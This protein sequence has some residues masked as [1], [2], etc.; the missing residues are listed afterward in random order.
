MK[1]GNVTLDNNIVLAPMAGITDKTYRSLAKKM[2]AGLVVT[3]MVSAKGLYYNDK[4]TDTL[5][6]ISDIE[7][8]VALQIFGSD[9]DI[10]ASVVKNNINNRLDID[11]ID[12]N[13]GCPAPKIVKNNDGSA[14]MKNPDLVKEIIYKVVNASKKPVTIKTRMGWDHKNLN[15]VEIAKIAEYEGASAVTIH[16]RTKEMF[17]SGKADWDYIKYVKEQ[18]EIPVIGN[19]DIFKPQDAINMLEYTLCDG[20]AIGRGAM[21]NPFIFKGIIDLLEGNE[22][23]NPSYLEIIDMAIMHLELICNDKGEKIGVREMRKHI[24]WYLKGMPESNKLKDQINALNSKQEVLNA[25][26]SYRNY[27]QTV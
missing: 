4:K 16:A 23:F 19:G 10:M 11:I 14:L 17:Y 1:I 3:E 21:G 18:V 12:I 20:V 25:L 27:I 9:P 5:M 22:P 15:G 24:S 7:R 13:M 8:P 2:G 6:D 26:M